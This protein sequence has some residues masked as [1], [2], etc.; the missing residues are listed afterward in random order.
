M[1]ARPAKT[2]NETRDFTMEM[3]RKLNEMRPTK[4]YDGN[5]EK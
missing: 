3:D 5:S 4:L 1:V 2:V